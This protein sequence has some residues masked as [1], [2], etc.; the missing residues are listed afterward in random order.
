MRHSWASVIMVMALAAVNA[1]SGPMVGFDLGVSSSPY[2]GARVRFAHFYAL[3][4]TGSVGIPRDEWVTAGL[5]LSNSFYLPDL[6]KLQH[7]IEVEAGGEVSKRRSAV[8]DWQFPLFLGYGLEYAFND[9]VS[10]TGALG[11]A[12]DVPD[13]ARLYTLR[14]GV[15]VILYAR[16]RGASEQPGGLD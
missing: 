16:R 6:H 5:A 13:G 4:V 9:V 10:L 11:L 12:S 3:R 2:V 15:G 7:F 8:P 14:T 1:A